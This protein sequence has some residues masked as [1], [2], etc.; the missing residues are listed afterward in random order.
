MS[1]VPDSVVFCSN[2]SNLSNFSLLSASFGQSA[3]S[4]SFDPWTFVDE[5]GRGKIYKTLLKSYRSTLSGLGEEIRNP[6][7][8][9]ASTFG[10]MP[11]VAPPSDRKRRRIEKSSSRSRASSVVEESPAGTS[12]Y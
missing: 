12:K 2:E 7:E 11:A 1:G 3:L 6:D 10:D 9:E 4:S 8:A 5:F